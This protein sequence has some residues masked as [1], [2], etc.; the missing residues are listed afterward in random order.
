MPMVSIFIICRLRCANTMRPQ[1]DM[2]MEWLKC[3]VGL[4]PTLSRNVAKTGYNVTA[5]S[6]QTACYAVFK[7]FRFGNT[8]WTTA[9]ETS[10]F[11]LQIQCPELVR[12]WRVALRDRD[13]DHWGKDKRPVIDVWIG[14]LYHVHSSPHVVMNAT[15]IKHPNPV[16][17]ISRN[18]PE[19][20]LDWTGLNWLEPVQKFFRNAPESV[21]Y[22]T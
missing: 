16:Q 2:L 13:S 18:V 6:Q 9:G 5:S 21:F 17:E 8:E 14:I 11:Y 7:A 12:V 3:P 22:T 15:S 4:I 10:N 19:P 1:R 20:E